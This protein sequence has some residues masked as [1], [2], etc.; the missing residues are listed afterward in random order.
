MTHVALQVGY[1][2]IVPELVDVEG[3]ASPATIV[4]ER[5]TA[6]HELVH[7][8]GG[9]IPTANH[10]NATGYPL[11]ESEVFTYA[12]A[13]PLS[14]TAAASDPK[15]VAT[16]IRT[17]RVLQISRAHFNCSS[18]PGA[19]L[20]DLPLGRGSHWEARV[21]GPELMSYGTAS[22]ETYVSD[23]TVAMLEDTHHYFVP[24]YEM[25][26]GTLYDETTASLDGLS[27]LG[28]ST[29]DV[30]P[31]YVPPPPR[32]RG[33][34]R[35]GI[36][37]GCGF[38]LGDPKTS[39]DDRHLCLKHSELGCTPDNRMAALC[40]VRPGAGVPKQYSCG[41]R[42]ADGGCAAGPS[43]TGCD[44]ADADCALPVE[45]QHFTPETLA[46]AW[47]VAAAPR[48]A[49]AADLALDRVGGF[50]ASMDFAPVRY[51]YWS[52]LNSA[53]GGNSSSR[54]STESGGSVS[55]GDEVGAASSD[56]TSRGGQTLCRD[57]R[58]FQSTLNELINGIAVG[59]AAY[60]MC[61]AA[62]C[63]RADY[64]Q[65][66]VRSGGVAYWYRCP[67]DGGKIFV[68]GF[69]GRVT[70]P[71]AEAF[72]AGETITG[73]KFPES[74][75][76][77]ETALYMGLGITLLVLCLLCLC[78]PVRNGCVRC[79]RR[80]CAVE[81]YELMSY[82][83]VENVS[84]A[85]KTRP[86]TCM[87]NCVLI[88]NTGTMSWGLF[89]VGFSAM[90]L[91][92]GT[93]ATA[94]IPLLGLGGI[95]VL[96]TALGSCG[97]RTDAFGPACATLI[98]MYASFLLLCAVMIFATTLALD[99]ASLQ[100]IVRKFFD[101]VQD[102]LP[103][104]VIDSSLSQDDQVAQAAAYLQASIV[105]LAAAL[106]SAVLIVFITT[107]V[108]AC[109]MRLATFAAVTFHFVA[110]SLQV[111]GVVLVAVGSYLVYNASR[112]GSSTQEALAAPGGAA[113]G[114]GLAVILS[115]GLGVCAGH[116][117]QR[118]WILMVFTLLVAMA[119]FGGSIAATVLAI[120]NRG[121]IN[122]I[123]GSLT[124]RQ[125][126]MLQGFLGGGLTQEELALALESQLLN[127]GIAC[128]AIILMSAAYFASGIVLLRTPIPPATASRPVHGAAIVPYGRGGKMPPGRRLSP[129]SVP[130][131]V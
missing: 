79:A 55:I 115:A 118:R 42:D 51:G 67:S 1:I 94:T 7:V 18:L 90:L 75:F 62:N 30:V 22:G 109:T 68:P 52:C 53:P 111:I 19:P 91:A 108:A 11:S 113:L 122:T 97:V 131:P 107:V 98:F 89:L 117:P 31:D 17:P 33:A 39:W 24:D 36:N 54:A 116:K 13:L 27:S 125:L 43:A 96:L 45:Q 48:S 86:S 16:F 127:V 49:T 29:A 72:C 70:C 3:Q 20:E 81:K 80:R 66:A 40:T 84:Y 46:D 104:H 74:G 59:R 2:N 47:S 44:G 82:D 119:W 130:P 63:Y 77:F 5:H 101:L 12:P 34:L 120:T 128:V 35:W 15:R 60:G 129:R 28:F 99:S 88:S 83:E 103:A 61:F 110:Y 58:C 93:I 106:I 100:L 6:L 8:L 57:C 41:M 56:Q 76:V 23:L 112:T 121:N 105:P 78:P 26:T 50:S 71:P 4:D 123:L 9:I 25:M 10:L 102:A 21:M 85:A 64:L 73:R 32:A 37:G 92:N 126:A 87:G 69:T 14:A 65:I 114:I 38:V 124:E 95:I